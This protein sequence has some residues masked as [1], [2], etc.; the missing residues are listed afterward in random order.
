MAKAYSVSKFGSNKIQTFDE[1]T[2]EVERLCATSDRKYIYGYWE[3]QESIEQAGYCIIYEAEK[4][5]LKRDS[6][7]DSTGLA[8][9]GHSISE[10]QLRIILSL[11]VNE[12]IIAMDKDI[13]IEEIRA[14]CEKFY[15]IRKVSYIYDRWDILGAKDSPADTC[16]KIYN[17]L[18]KHRIV[19]DESEHQKYLKSLENK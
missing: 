17:F 10:E 4:S 14:I 1:L 3:N 13:P 12:I 18:F 2:H 5:V 8:L 6:R 9:H 15:R 7:N 11:N 19:Y 16:N